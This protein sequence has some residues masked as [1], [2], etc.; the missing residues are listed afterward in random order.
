MITGRPPPPPPHDNPQA[1]DINNGSSDWLRLCEIHHSGALFGCDPDG[2]CLFS[3]NERLSHVS[4]LKPTPGPPNRP[5]SQKAS[6]DGALWICRQR[7]AGKRR[8]RV[9][10]PPEG[11]QVRVHTSSSA[12]QPA[13]KFIPAAPSGVTGNLPPLAFIPVCLLFH[14]RERR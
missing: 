12:A 5:V 3:A 11:F 14:D 9:R 2:S 4:G 13:S 10:E 8:A 6:R 1:S 7:R